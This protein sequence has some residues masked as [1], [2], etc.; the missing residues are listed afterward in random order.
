MGLTLE[1]ITQD[2]V[3]A[4]DWATFHYTEQIGQPDEL[5]VEV[6]AFTTDPLFTQPVVDLFAL[7]NLGGFF[8]AVAKLD[9]AVLFSGLIRGPIG[10]SK[11]APGSMTYSLKADGWQ[12]LAPKKLVGTP[13]TWSIPPEDEWGDVLPTAIWVDPRAI[14]R[15]VA[16]SVK[17]LWQAYWHYPAIDLDTFVADV[18]PV[19]AP[20]PDEIT[21]SGSDLEGATSDLAAAGSAAALWW[22]AND[23]PNDGDLL[24]APHLALHFDNVALPD[25]GDTGDDL[26]AGFPS[27]DQPTNVA[28]Y[29]ISDTPDWITSIMATAM[30]FTP[31]NT[32]RIDSAYVRGATGN[33]L[34]VLPAPIS[35]PVPF[36]IGLEQ[37][38]GTGW[39]GAEDGGIWGAEYVDAPA[40]VSKAQRDAFGQAFLASRGTPTWTGT[41]E[42]EGY[43]GWH[44]GQAVQVTDADYGF[45][46]RWFLIR[47]VTMTQTDPFAI[48]NK[49]TLTLGDTLSLSLG[50]ALR[51]Q[52]LAEQRKPI[53]PA[54]QFIP[55]MGDLQPEPGGTLVVRMQAATASGSQR[56]VAGVGAGWSLLINGDWAT[57]RSTTPTSSGCRTRRS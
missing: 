7:T 52:R 39:V 34:D 9:G 51:A 55:Y 41:V 26:L 22:L 19:D 23:S 16:A 31:D 44:K 13:Y 20:L 47:A 11:K 35:F 10:M 36:Q 45:D 24:V 8:Y 17:A 1:V 14:G 12:F 42:V 21:W 48:S 32:Q 37:E 15:P 46:D 2:I 3:A 28:P 29:A 33:Y 43:D 6:T 30:T 27:A 56:K 54:T 49:Y 18:L 57:I 25:P 5:T 40:A 53:D 4:A 38:G 50:Y